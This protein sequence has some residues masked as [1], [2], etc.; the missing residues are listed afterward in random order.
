MLAMKYFFVIHVSLLVT[1]CTT[2]P[3]TNIQFNQEQVYKGYPCFDQ[4]EEFK[5]GYDLAI[6]QKLTSY[7]S[8]SNITSAMQSGCKAGV[9]EYNFE[10]NPESDLRIQ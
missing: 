3:D 2:I 7:Q 9:N 4:C 6:S 10:N 1:A 8:C 5:S